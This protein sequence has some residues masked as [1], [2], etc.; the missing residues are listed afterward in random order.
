M[1]QRAP[2]GEGMERKVRTGSQPTERVSERSAELRPQIEPART[3]AEEGSDSA[4]TARDKF[5]LRSNQHRRDVRCQVIARDTQPREKT[6][7]RFNFCRSA[8][9]RGCAEQH[10]E[11]HASSTVRGLG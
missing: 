7:Q 1:D 4:T 11:A 8:T 9:D 5:A 3:S 6:R 2:G 10:R